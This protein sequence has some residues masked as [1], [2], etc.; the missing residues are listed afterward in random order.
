MRKEGFGKLVSL[1]TAKNIIF[2]LSREVD[3]EKVS[4]DVA[5]GRV[6]A[7]DIAAS[8]DVPPFAKSAMDGY[9]VIA[10]D[11][12][13]ASNT[14]P[15]KLNQVGQVYPGDYPDEQVT[16]GNCFEIATGA[17]IPEGADAVLMVEYTEK[18]DDAITIYRAVAPG[19]NV[20]KAGSDI[21]SGETVLNKGVILNPRL[22]AV[23]AAT[24]ISEVPVKRKPIVAV[25]STG[26]EL[27]RAPEKLGKGQIYETNA[28]SLIDGL[29]EIQCKPL[30]L[31]IASDDKDNLRA[32]IVEAVQNADL[33]LLTGGSSMGA[34]DLLVEVLS[35]LG[36]VI[37]HG[38]AVKP[39]KPTIISKVSDK[40]VFGLPGHP[41]SAL[42]NFYILVKPLIYRMLGTAMPAE[43][44]IE[45]KIT[46]KIASTIGRFEFL[47][48]K[49]FEESGEFFAEPV[50]KGSS[51]I[52]TLANASGFVEI[53]E[54]VEVVEKHNIVKV[55][56]F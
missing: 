14:H 43:V 10:S 1:E 39:G 44:I 45:A 6:L 20:I 46:R 56:L 30:D 53:D 5:L 36:E 8:V 16:E 25:C 15:K 22:S 29:R 9:A 31:G 41:A 23:L 50:L 11:T 13:G 33:V 35:E 52:T 34:T 54:N 27:V 4:I 37:V 2:S 47:A 26:N 42:S 28:R 32:K 48:V 21:K 12:F 51:A 24:G 38:I 19:E 40:I 55:K 17:P 18:N 7:E 49:T 3:V